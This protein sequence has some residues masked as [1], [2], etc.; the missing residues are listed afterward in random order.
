MR[1]SLSISPANLLVRKFGNYRDVAGAAGWH[2][3]VR[4]GEGEYESLSGPH[5]TEL[6]ALIAKKRIEGGKLPL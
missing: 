4:D 6:M 5:Y 3:V 1:H 2:V